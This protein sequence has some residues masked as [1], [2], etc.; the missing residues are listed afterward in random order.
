MQASFVSNIH[1]QFHFNIHHRLL[2]ET[3]VI[4]YIYSSLADNH[5]SFAEKFAQI[6]RGFALHHLATLAFITIN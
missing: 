5:H 2:S 3:A 1:T 4:K 6:L